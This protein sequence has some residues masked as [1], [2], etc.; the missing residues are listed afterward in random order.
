MILVHKFK[1][2]VFKATV[3]IVVGNTIR[4]ALD[5]AEDRTSEVLG[6]YTEKE[7]LSMRANTQAYTDESGRGK[8]YLLFKYTAKPGEISHEVK[9]LI[10]LAFMWHG[11]ALS[12]E[13]DEME[14]YYLED[15]VDRAYRTVQRFRKKYIKPKL[16]RLEQKAPNAILF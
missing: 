8:Y 6:K 15:I 4:E 14:C 3:H 5:W 1:L 10:N 13:N 12:A 16:K 2:P 9:H 11:H 7:K